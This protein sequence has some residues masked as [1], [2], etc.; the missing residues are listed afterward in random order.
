VQAPRLFRIYRFVKLL[1]VP[2][3][4]IGGLAA[5]AGHRWGGVVLVT[6]VAVQIGSHFAVGTWAYRDVMSRPWPDVQRINDDWD[7]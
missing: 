5:A 3:L 7:E 6:D 2:A 4:V 1:D